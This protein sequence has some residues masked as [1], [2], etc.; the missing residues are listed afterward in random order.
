MPGAWDRSLGGIAAGRLTG[1]L[2]KG[3]AMS[4]FL[5]PIHYLMFSKIKYQDDFC[6]FLI[7]KAEEQAPGFEE[8]IREHVYTVPE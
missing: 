1:K 4:A 6:L 3:E 7:A 2:S 5:G 8:Q